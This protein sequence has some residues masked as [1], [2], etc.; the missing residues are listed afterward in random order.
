MP[1]CPSSKLR[2]FGEVQSLPTLATHL[3][4]WPGQN[5]TWC[6]YLPCPLLSTYLSSLLIPQHWVPGEW[7]TPHQ[8]QLSPTTRHATF[9]PG[10]AD[11]SYLLFLCYGHP[12][13][14][15][16]PW[17]LALAGR[18][19]STHIGRC[20][21]IMHGTVCLRDRPRNPTMAAA[22]VDNIWHFMC[23]STSRLIPF[24]DSAPAQV[25]VPFLCPTSPMSPLSPCPSLAFHTSPPLN[26]GNYN[27]SYYCQFEILRVNES[28]RSKRSF[29]VRKIVLHSDTVCIR[30][31]QLWIFQV[32]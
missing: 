5:P 7:R 24:P 6:L 11:T 3:P 30:T 31:S 27:K 19:S 18:L 15:C 1:R 10:N 22:C 29:P 28:L 4:S 9:F 8:P 17:V 25:R 21:P 23:G 13:F 32:F 14:Q 26:R 20:L 16:T 2:A 12:Q